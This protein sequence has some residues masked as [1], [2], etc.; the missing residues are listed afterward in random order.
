MK[1]IQ[2]KN[3]GGLDNLILVES[4][5]PQ[6]LT[7]EVLVRWRATSLNFHDYL[8]AN[9][10]IPVADG[11]VPMSDGAGEVVAIGAG[12]KKWQVG[13]KVMSLFFPNWLDGLASAATTNRTSGENSPGFATELSCVHAESLTAMPQGYSFS[14]AATL[15]CAALTAWRALVVEGRIKVG[16]RVL[17]EGSGGMSIFALQIA[18]AAGAFVYATTSNKDKEQRLISLGADH[19]LN[20]RTDENWGKTVFKHSGGGVEHVLDVG[21]GTTMAQSVEAIG[22]GGNVASIG[23]LGGRKAEFVLPKLFF[24]HAH[25]NGIAVGN[26]RAQ[27][28]MVRAIEQSEWRPVIDK[29]FGLSEISD[30]FR[31]QETGQ[32]FGKI[33]LEF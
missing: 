1:S 8:V 13:N 12:V 14:E 18:K 26:R 4:D 21:G 27:E 11:Q 19:V 25:I 31:Y 30:A 32:H 23:I 5:E 15:P 33:V 10:S 7:G 16:D 6:P 17:V 20:Y 2:I 9:G 29:S 28:E 22:F 24:K 3:Q